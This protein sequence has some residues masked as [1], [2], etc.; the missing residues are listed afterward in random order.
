MPVWNS[1]HRS[2]VVIARLAVLNNPLASLSDPS[3]VSLEE[4]FR[5]L[6]SIAVSLSGI[7][8]NRETIF[9]LIG[10]R[11]S[12]FEDTK[13]ARIVNTCRENEAILL[14]LVRMP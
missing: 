11:E 7:R 1:F 3:S 6:V 5:V 12:F 8:S 13:L 14:Y 4:T 10:L 2:L 9:R